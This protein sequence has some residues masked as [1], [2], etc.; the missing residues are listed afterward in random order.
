MDCVKG[1]FAGIGQER[2]PKLLQTKL[3]VEQAGQPACSPLPRS[4]NCEI[5]QPDLNHALV[6]D[7]RSLLFGKERH[8]PWMRPSVLK[9]FDALSPSR[10]LAVVDLAK[11]KYLALD[12]MACPGPGAPNAPP[13]GSRTEGVWCPESKWIR[14]R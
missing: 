11:V 4:F 1:A 7:F 2:I 8:L 10:L 5:L 13:S 9:D 12:N 14:P 3:L 6:V